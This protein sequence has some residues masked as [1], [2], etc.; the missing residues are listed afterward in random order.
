[1]VSAIIALGKSMMKEGLKAGASQVDITPPVGVPLTGFILRE[2]NS[3]GVHDRLYA[4]VLVLSDGECLAALAICDVLGLDRHFVTS[5]RAS[6][7]E[8]TRIPGRNVM[9]CSTH[10][11]SGPAT[12]FLRDCGD[13]DRA[14]LAT[15]RQQLV[16]ASETALSNLRDA[17]IGAGYGRVT[18]GVQNRRIPGNPI[19]PQLA[20]LRVEDDRGQLMAA[21]LNYACHPTCV[22]DD[23]QLI[24]ADY[25]GRVTKA[26]QRKTGA[27]V[28]FAT[29][30]AG[31]VGPS[32]ARGFTCA[33]ALG[34]A[35][36]TEALRVLDDIAVDGRRKLAVARDILELPLQDIPSAENMERIVT[37]NRRLLLMAQEASRPSE[38]KIHRA[39][40]GWSET[41][42]AALTEGRVPRSVPAEVQV[43]CL[44]DIALVGVPGELFA[45]LGLTI[46]QD[47]G[48]GQVFICGYA[49]DNIGYIPTAQAYAQGGYEINRA[50]KYCGYPAALAS[51]A[52]EQLAETAA[53]LIKS[54]VA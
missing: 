45:E 52:G 15:L 48:A 26:I 30:A 3:E 7:Q 37:D 35:L 32:T 47:S 14:Y 41:I 23:N 8:A 40:L 22:W 50:F 49:N 9:I 6:I 13:V 27:I 16:E 21:L 2:G 33:E 5:V 10:T 39:M 34:S 1:M 12:M 28:M 20:V 36:A 25:P 19:D 18:E 24:S 42:L 51:D 46:K 4:R 44:G 17:R 53:R 31:D 38:A 11:H 43:I 29:G 54:C